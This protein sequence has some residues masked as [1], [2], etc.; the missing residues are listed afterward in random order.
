VPLGPRHGIT[1]ENPREVKVLAIA[2]EFR[3]NGNLN[4]GLGDNFFQLSF[5]ER[6]FQAKENKK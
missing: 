4:P 5:V 6:I 1:A 3:G 2:R